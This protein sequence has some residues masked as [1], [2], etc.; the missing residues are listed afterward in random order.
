MNPARHPLLTTFQPPFANAMHWQEPLATRLRYRHNLPG[1]LATRLL[2][3]E[4]GLYVLAELLPTAAPEDLP[5]ILNNDGTAWW[6]RPVW[7]PRQHRYLN[8]ARMLLAPYKDRTVW[9]NALA[10][11]RTLSPDLRAFTLDGSGLDS[12]GLDSSG[13]WNAELGKY[14]L[15]ERAVVL[16]GALY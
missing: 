7:S 5:D 1:Q 11:Y 4:L 10:K 6:E 2:N 15:R 9:L 3:V 12:S 8:R 13:L 16:R 14:E